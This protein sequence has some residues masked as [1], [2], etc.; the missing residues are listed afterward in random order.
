MKETGDLRMVRA[1]Q[2]VAGP[3]GAPVSSAGTPAGPASP[4]ATAAG[5]ATQPATTDSSQSGRLGSQHS[6]VRC[7]GQ[8][9]GVRRTGGSDRGTPA[10]PRLK[11][12][13]RHPPH[14]PG[15][16][17][18]PRRRLKYRIP[19]VMSPRLLRAA[20]YWSQDRAM[21]SR[22]RRRRPPRPRASSASGRPRRAPRLSVG[23]TRS[24]A[25]E[26]AFCRSTIGIS[27]S[28]ATP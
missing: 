19:T 6:S 5:T 24:S 13:E 18:I 22:Q 17:R 10:L 1:D 2:V 14:V 15:F 26:I 27:N 21:P 9:Q 4:A 3:P 7:R 25:R 8:Q 20:V 11:R 28:M 16:S 12:R 23:T